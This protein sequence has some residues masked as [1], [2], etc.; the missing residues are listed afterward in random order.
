MSA[1]LAVIAPVAGAVSETFIRRHVEGLLPGRTVAMTTS[2]RGTPGRWSPDVPQLDLGRPPAGL[3]AR[4]RLQA[5]ERLGRPMPYP[6]FG[7]VR[8]FVREHGVQVLLCEYLDVATTW[9]PLSRDLGLRLAAHAHGHDVSSLLTK[10]SWAKAY[11][12]LDDAAVVVTMSEFSRNRLV[13]AGLDARRVR[14]IPYGVSVPAAP[15]RR[16]SQG[17]VRV[18]AV[19]RMVAKKAPILLLDAFRR[20]HDANQAMTLD[21]VGAGPLLPA[22]RQYV[23]ALDLEPVVTFHGAVPNTRVQELMQHADVFLQHSMTDDDG[24]QEGLPVAILEAMAAG[25][26]VVSTLHAGIP[27]AVAHARTGWL[28][29]EG[30]AEAMAQGLVMLARDEHARREFGAAGWKVAADRFNWDLQRLALLDAL[31]LAA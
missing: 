30:D 24:D 6:G 14:V 31:G 27:E 25:L 11:R 3:L 28:T 18:L 8:G 5:L 17:A 16:D 20:A 4:A 21:V 2:T 13:N 12:T 23:R 15:W 19:G 26:P 22:A 29:P 1:P 10:P 7:A 9:M